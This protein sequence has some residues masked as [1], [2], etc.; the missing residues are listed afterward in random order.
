[1]RSA[2]E[3]FTS[4]GFTVG[5]YLLSRLAEI[6]IRHVFG[7]PGDYNLAFLDHIEDRAISRPLT[8]VIRGV[9]RS[10]MDGSRRRSSDVSGQ[11][12]QIPKL[13]VCRYSLYLAA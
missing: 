8:P 2:R 10:L 5:D 6:G 12:V 1:V 3:D 4:D 11:T 7:V 9:S 13:T